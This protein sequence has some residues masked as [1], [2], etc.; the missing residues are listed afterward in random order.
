MKCDKEKTII[1]GLLFTTIV[2]VGGIL[3]TNSYHQVDATNEIKKDYD[4][5]YAELKTD[6]KTE[7]VEIKQDIK[8]IKSYLMNR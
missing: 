7:L 5:R 4:A 2:F 1:Y 6:V 8:D 3:A